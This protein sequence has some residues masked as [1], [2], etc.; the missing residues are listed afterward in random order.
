MI[1]LHLEYVQSQLNEN[2]VSEKYLKYPSDEFLS[3]QVVDWKCLFLVV[4]FPL[5]GLQLE[6]VLLCLLEG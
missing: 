4:I 6:F 1:S 3:F 2:Q 5:K